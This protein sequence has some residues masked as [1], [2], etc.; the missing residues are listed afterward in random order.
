MTSLDPPSSTTIPSIDPHALA[1]GDPPSPSSSPPAASQPPPNSPLFKHLRILILRHL[2]CTDRTLLRLSRLFSSPSSTDALLCTLGYTLELLSSLLSKALSTRLTTLAS[3]LATNASSIILPG[4]TLIATIPA[5]PSA[6]LLAQAARTSKALAVVISDYRIFVRLWGIIGIYSWARDT[7]H[8][9]L[10]SPSSNTSNQPSS[11]TKD[12]LL[13]AIPYAQIL[14]CAAFQILENGA[15]LSSKNILTSSSWSGEAGKAREN[16]WWIL[17]SRFWALH[18]ALEFLRLYLQMQILPVTC[19]P[20]SSSN[21]PI[22]DD[23]NEKDAKIR[24]RERQWLWMRDLLSNIAYFPMTIH[25]SLE[26]GLLGETWVAG[27]GAVAGGVLL[28]DAWRG[29]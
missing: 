7:Y 25:W 5:P 28:V 26:K 20:K 13:R 18:V 4:E 21:S 15:Y 1:P 6:K 14:S 2:S 11:W 3:T 17:S 22:E 24:G 10:Q 16:R 8:S 29:T 23:D 9:G 27:L 19:A 12:R